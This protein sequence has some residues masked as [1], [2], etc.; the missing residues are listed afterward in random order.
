MR[1]A[2]Q[3]IPISAPKASTPQVKPRPNASVATVASGGAQ[4]ERAQDGRPIEQL[5]AARHD[6]VD[7]QG[8]FDPIP[9]EEDR[10]E[11]Y[12]ERRGTDVQADAPDHRS[13]DR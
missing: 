9:D 3:V 13:A 5:S 1:Q 10:S 11:R 8:A 2:A 7:G 12:S 6:V 4:G